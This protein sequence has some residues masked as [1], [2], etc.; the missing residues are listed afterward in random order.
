MCSGAVLWLGAQG[1][2]LHTCNKNSANA[3]MANRGAMIAE[4]MDIGIQ[5]LI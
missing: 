5:L 2:E 1:T 4:N 3:G